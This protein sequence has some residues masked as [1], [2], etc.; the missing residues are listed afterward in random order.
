MFFNKQANKKGQW[1]GQLPTTTN[2][3]AQHANSAMV[4]KSALA[5]C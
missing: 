5:T 4:R 3:P 2:D 1:T